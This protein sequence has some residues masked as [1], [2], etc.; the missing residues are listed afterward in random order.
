ME[1]KGLGFA[2]VI[3]SAIIFGSMP[4]LAKTIYANGGNA[5]S[6]IFYRFFIALPVLFLII[7]KSKEIDIRINKEELKS[8]IL[9]S[10]FGYSA[11]ATLLF[12]SYNF[13]SSGMA[14]TIHFTYPVFVVLGGMFFYK[15]KPH[16][17]K[18]LCVILCTLGVV[19]FSNNEGGNSI[20]GI[21]LAFISGIRYSFYI[22]YID[23]SGLKTM[24]SFKLTFYLCA[25]SSVFVLIF[26]LITGDF[27]IGMTPLGW[28]LTIVLSLSVTV[29]AV[30]L[31]Q[32]GIKHIGSQNAAIFSTFEPITSVVI[33]ILV[34]DEVFD[35]KTLLG[36]ILILSAVII[37]AL[38][39]RQKHT[40]TI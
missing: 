22:L 11:T 7:K 2:A 37:T 40:E 34:F 24:S 25:I 17:L 10:I 19:L 26:S 21:A 39:E 4:L 18:V 6:L 38:S 13:I 23:K 36:S 30:T 33:G 5:V 15:D 35:F 14:T 12:L 16:F 31:F 28:T 27:T 1:K 8:L 9:I 29:G 3:V 32:Y 20:L